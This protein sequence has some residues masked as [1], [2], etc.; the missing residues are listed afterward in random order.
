MWPGDQ[1]DVRRWAV[2]RIESRPD[3]GPRGKNWEEYSGVLP[4]KL[5]APGSLVPSLSL[6]NTFRGLFSAKG[7]GC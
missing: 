1:R 5:E 3:W 2:H 7:G 4:P 6:V